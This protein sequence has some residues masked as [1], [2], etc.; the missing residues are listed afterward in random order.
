MSS[1]P[2][3]RVEVYIDGTY[4]FDVPHGDKR[5][6]L[7]KRFPDNEQAGQSGFSSAFNWNQLGSGSMKSLSVP[8]T[9]LGRQ[10]SERLI[11][12]SQHSIKALLKRAMCLSWVG[13]QSVVSVIASSSVAH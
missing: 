10:Q 4:R 9:H 2:I 6:E 11:S 7:V 8:S 12:L 3:E 13:H 1:E 5:N